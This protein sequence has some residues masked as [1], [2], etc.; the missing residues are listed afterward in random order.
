[1]SVDLQYPSSLHHGRALLPVCEPRGLI[2]IRINARELLAVRVENRRLPMKM[3]PAFVASKFWLAGS[4]SGFQ[5][6]LRLNLENYLNLR[7]QGASILR[8]NKSTAIIISDS[9][10]EEGTNAL[11]ARRGV[12]PDAEV[13]KPFQV[14]R[15]PCRLE[16]SPIHTRNHSPAR[17]APAPFPG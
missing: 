14:R 11:F 5:E 12:P 1:M 6:F 9:K 7:P 8:P 15:T 17:R 4:F 3:F 16:I 10:P 2:A 13:L